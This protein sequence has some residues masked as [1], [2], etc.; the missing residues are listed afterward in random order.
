[1]VYRAHDLNKAGEPGDRGHAS[2]DGVFALNAILE[3]LSRSVTH[4]LNV[5]FYLRLISLNQ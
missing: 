5:A 2:E 1:M 4:A 3:G